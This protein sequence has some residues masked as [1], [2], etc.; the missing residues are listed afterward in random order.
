[1][2]MLT[3]D[4]NDR[5][6]QSQGVSR[7]STRV[8]Q[9]IQSERVGM[10]IVSKSH[11]NNTTASNE[12]QTKSWNGVVGGIRSTRDVVERDREAVDSW[13][14]FILKAPTLVCTM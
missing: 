3:E 2:M 9:S 7:S 6:F 12:R 11:D 1:M 5:N 8:A 14:P 10:E 13:G 4:T